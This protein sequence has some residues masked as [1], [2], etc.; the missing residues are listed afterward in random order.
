MAPQ[1]ERQFSLLPHLTLPAAPLANVDQRLT[2]W[3]DDTLPFGD[4][5]IYDGPAERG[6]T[7]ESDLAPASIG[8]RGAFASR[9]GLIVCGFLKIASS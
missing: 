5:V 7:K 4:G 3:V 8:A 2:L 6:P 9:S 1:A